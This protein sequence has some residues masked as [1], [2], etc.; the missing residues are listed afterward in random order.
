[1]QYGVAYTAV[2]VVKSIHCQLRTTYTTYH[3]GMR[4][5]NGLIEASAIEPLPIEP[6]PIE[7]LP[8]EPPDL[9][10]DPYYDTIREN[11]PSS[12]SVVS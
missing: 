5:A 10:A 2:R 12:N 8:I 4:W 1:V 11:R 7:P 9:C 6:L 3:T